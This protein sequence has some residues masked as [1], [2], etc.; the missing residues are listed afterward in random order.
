MSIDT[1][2][3]LTLRPWEA[4][5]MDAVIAAF[6]TADMDNQAGQPIRDRDTGHE[7]L[8]WASNLVGRPRGFGFAVCAHDWPIGNV[9]VTGIDS[10]EVGWVSYWT[11]APARGRRVATDALTALVEFVHDKHGV[12]RLE[13]GHRLNN[14]A[15]GAVAQS[16]GFLREGIERA[17]LSYDGERY[18]VARWARLT[19]D[20]RPTLR[21]EVSIQ[22]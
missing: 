22:L 5:D 13:L 14:P 18:D 21:R 3:P 16:A 7:W 4:R 10:H 8:S 9:A 1:N 6:A 19:E 17:K 20:P 11:A 2:T 12:Q 15:S